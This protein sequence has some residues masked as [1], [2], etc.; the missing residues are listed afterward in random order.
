MS[1]I[2]NPFVI[3]LDAN[4]MY[5]FRTRDV[6]FTFAQQG[7]FRARFT[8]Q[9]I[10]EWTRSL[11]RNKPDLA[12]SVKEQAAA[13]RDVFQE[14]FVTGYEPLIEGFVLPDPDD[15]HVL[16]AAIKCSAQIIV[17]ENLKDFPSEILDEHD[18]EAL[19]ADDVLANTFDLFPIDGARALRT[20]RKRYGNPPFT[21]SEFLLDL[22]KSGMPK[23][24]AMARSSIEYL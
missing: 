24:A 16:A 14:C 13:V 9:I 10:D 21:P 1:H 6:L 15:R 2:A 23:L 19:G 18:I 20:V 7:L 8:E 17:T 11:I 5:P 22:T 12:E 4:V 3:L